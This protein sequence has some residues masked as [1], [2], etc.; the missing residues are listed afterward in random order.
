[1]ASTQQIK[2]RIKSVRSTEQVIAYIDGANLYSGTKSDGWLVDY[3][4]FTKWLADKYLV[5]K[6]YM[7]IGM[8]EGNS[9]LYSF[10]NPSC[11]GEMEKLKVI[12]TQ[13][14]FYI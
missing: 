11:W 1:M 9:A 14:W 2:G 13:I 3:G 6:V 7:F 10:L 12:V 5:S 8:V 4:R